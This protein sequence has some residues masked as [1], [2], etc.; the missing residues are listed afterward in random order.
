MSEISLGIIGGG[1]LGSMLSVA[2][3]KLNIKTIIYSDDI[4]SPA[5]NFCDEIIFGK[6]N[7]KEKLLEFLNKVNIITY[8]FENIPYETLNELNKKKSV[9][10]KPSINRLIQHR[11][12]EKDFINKLNIRTTQYASVEKK[13]DLESLKDFIPGILKTTTLGYD[14][15]GQYPIKEVKDIEGLN[16]D[17][18]KGYILEKLVKLKKEISIIITRFNNNDYEIYEPIENTHE[19][20]ILKYSKIPAEINHAL[21][22]QSKDWA[23]TIAEELK[24][25]GTLCVEF[26]ID[27]NDNLF[28]NEIAPRVHNSGHLTINAYNVSQFENHIRAVCSLNKIPLKKLSDAKMVNLIGNQI[29]PYRKNI[30]LNENEFFFDYL[31]KEIKDKRKMGHITTLI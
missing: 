18:S 27:K 16:I 24:Y 5:K 7:D 3:K 23:I 28:V 26:F 4:D 25:I 22:N 30:K 21:F 20:Q 14:G 17:F 9:L 8:E 15:K 1:Q 13:S 10:P 11:L 2:A 12:A 6:Y 29:E 31:K 19:N